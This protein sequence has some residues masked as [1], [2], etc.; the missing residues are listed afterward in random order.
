M[1]PIQLV[2]F[3]MAGTTVRDTGEVEHCFLAAAAA[4]GLSADRAQVKAM[5]GWSKKRVFETLWQQQIGRDHGDFE[6]R[7]NQSFAEFR[8]RLETHYRTQP[9]EPTPGCLETFAELKSRGV[10]VALTTGFY[11]EVTNIILSRLGWDA[12][13]DG[14]YVGDINGVIQASVT[15]SEIYGS[16]GRPSPYMIQKAM[17]QLGVKDPQAVIAV[18]DT[19]ADLAAGINAHCGWSVGVTSGS[20]SRSQLE[21]CPHHALIDALP[22]LIALID[23]L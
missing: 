18:G 16:E 19:P 9:V 17:Y 21:S 22:E 8:D 3:D 14:P 10:L 12:G 5:M 6:T 2:A 1:S 13:L 7:V 20:H 4:T 23:G 15:P 11:R